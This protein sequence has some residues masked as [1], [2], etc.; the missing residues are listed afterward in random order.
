MNHYKTFTLFPA[1]E[2]GFTL[3]LAALISSV[4][5]S[6]GT[7]IYVIAHKQ[8]LLSSLSRDSQFAFYAADTAAECALYWDSRQN[9]F[10]TTTPVLATAA[11]CDAV[12]LTLSGSQPSQPYTYPYSIQFQLM[13]NNKCTNTNVLKECVGGSLDPTCLSAGNSV[14]TTIHADGYNVTC[15]ATTTSATTLERSVELSY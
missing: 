14:R 3:L 4:V 6:V 15:A 5:L 13:L 12:A 7:A 11:T 8:L 10:A 1:Q 2:R 9:Y